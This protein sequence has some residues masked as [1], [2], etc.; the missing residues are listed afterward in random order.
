[1]QRSIACSPTQTN[2]QI[3]FHG[4]AESPRVDSARKKRQRGKVPS[5]LPA[6]LTALS[7]SM[8][9]QAAFRL[10]CTAVS[11]DRLPFLD[12]KE[13]CI[14]SSPHFPKDSPD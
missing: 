4:F 1:L 14:F 11:E 3:C 8:F 13:I 5:K 7:V 10:E 9:L 6:F 2:F 12:V